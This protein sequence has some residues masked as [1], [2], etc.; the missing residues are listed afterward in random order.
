L[1]EVTVVL[2]YSGDSEKGDSTGKVKIVSAS[3]FVAKGYHRTAD[4]PRH[5]SPIMADVGHQCIIYFFVAN[6]GF[7]QLI[8]VH[9]RIAAVCWRSR[10]GS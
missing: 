8:E 1:T 6:H 4:D 7:R 5:L 10:L 2:D 3:T 9:L